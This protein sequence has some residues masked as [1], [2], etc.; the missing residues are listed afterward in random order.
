MDFIRKEISP[1][2]SILIWSRL[3]SE[4][5]RD[6]LIAQAPTLKK[7]W[8]HFQKRL[9]NTKKSGDQEEYTKLVFSSEWLFSAIM[10]FLGMLYDVDDSLISSQLSVSFELQY[11]TRFLELLISL[12]SQLPT[13]R[14]TND[15]LLDTHLIPVIKQS[16]LFKSFLSND[17]VF[18][19]L[20]DLLDYYL[21]L[22]I[23]V[24]TGAQLSEEEVQEKITQNFRKLRQTAFDKFPE[25]AKFL[26]QSNLGSLGT[27]E[28]L[29]DHISTLSDDQLKEFCTYLNFRTSYPIASI[30]ITS[31]REFL[32]EC[33]LYRYETRPSIQEISMSLETMPTEQSLFSSILRLTED[34]NS[35]FP[36]PLPKMALQYLSTLD[37][38]MRSFQLERYESFYDI[39]SDIESALSRLKPQIVAG[40]SKDGEYNLKD[41]QLKLNGSSKMAARI[42]TPIS[43]FEVAPPKVGS[44]NVVTNGLSNLSSSKP[45]FRGISQINSD[46]TVSTSPGSVKAEVV[47][48]LEGYNATPNVVN[49][50]DSL[51]PGEVVF[52]AELLTPNPKSEHACEQAGIRYLR[53]AEI[54]QVLD[55]K[56][57]PIH[58]L[59]RN[60]E[61]SELEFE[62]D[63]DQ[64]VKENDDGRNGDRRKKQQRRI[65]RR[66]LH[67]YLDELQYSKDPEGFYSGLNVV[68]RRRSR[69]N[70]FYP[71]L[72]N[73]KALT[74]EKNVTPDWLTD[75]FL[76]FGDPSSASY[77]S[78]HELAVSESDT[79]I[80]FPN[81][82]DYRDTFLDS[83]HLIE[84]F[85]DR[86]VNVISIR[87]I[88]EDGTVATPPS[89]SSKKRKA[90]DSHQEKVVAPPYVLPGYIPHVS[91][92]A[93][94]QPD[95][96]VL[97]AVS[98]HTPKFGDVKTNQI[99]YTPRQVQALVTSTGPG[100]TVIVGPPGT[101]KTD[102]AVQVVSNLYHN[103]PDQRTL[104]I[105]HSNQALN[106]IFEK[107]VELDVDDKHLLR[108]GGGEEQIDDRVRKS[109]GESFSKYGRVERLLQEKVPL[110]YQVDRLAGSMGVYGAY[111]DSCDTGLAFYR[112][113]VK[114]KWTTYRKKIAELRNKVN[115]SK[116]NKLTDA[117]TS[118]VVDEFPF[119]EYFSATGNDTR[120]GQQ[121]VFFDKNSNAWKNAKCGEHHA[122]LPSATL[123]Q[124][125]YDITALSFDEAVEKAE[126]AYRYIESHFSSLS[127]IRPF[128][129]IRSN[130]AKA[131][132]MLVKQARVIV[133]TAT[134]A[135]M[136]RQEIV[137]MGFHYDNVVVEEAAQLTEIET[138]MLLTLQ[139]DIPSSIRGGFSEVYGEK[140]EEMAE[141]SENENNQEQEQDVNEEED[142][143]VGGFSGVAGI[144]RNG[145]KSG[146]IKQFFGTA[147]ESNAHGDT[148][149]VS[150][151]KS[152]IISVNNRITRVV[153]IGDDRQNAPIIKNSTLRSYSKLDQSL[154]GRLV[155]LNTPL[156]VLDTQGRARPE[157]VTLYDWQYNGD[158]S[159]PTTPFLKHLPKIL[160][161]PLL[162]PQTP[163]A[164]FLDVCQFINVGPYQNQ[165][166]TEP[167]RHFIQ[168]LGEAEYAVAIYQYM[169]LLGYP[170]EKI[171]I[172][173][174]YYGQKKLIEEIATKRCGKP[175]SVFAKSNK[176]ADPASISEIFG[177]PG[178]GIKTVDEYQGEQN[179]Y[180]ILSMVRTKRVGYLRDRRRL[181]VALSRARR[182][183]YVLGYEPLMETFAREEPMMAKLLAFNSTSGSDGQDNKHKLKIVT[184]E[185]Y[186]A[187][188]N[189]ALARHE[190][191]QDKQPEEPAKKK[192]SKS[193]GAKKEEAEQVRNPNAER[194]VFA[195]ENVEHIGQYVHQM[196][197]T[198]RNFLKDQKNMN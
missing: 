156:V 142:E 78:L 135:S 164:G 67:V 195:I 89:S 48:D 3:S 114:P 108:L 25:D 102:V 119:S 72:K 99:R 44:Y 117:I 38:L 140:E 191:E 65:R 123:S 143:E 137:D 160:Q 61:Y 124:Q 163:N 157:I 51:R 173:C 182:G 1:L 196:A 19:Q 16:P 139:K 13:R 198:R 120:N 32:T 127:E 168:N 194:N 54:I 159:D 118:E 100:L 77:D 23:N 42:S 76:G 81:T 107:I 92:T 84:S 82:V 151:N 80:R 147:G 110:L 70:N 79:S 133:M 149:V 144:D 20:V 39:K 193:K 169:R 74:F 10:G 101:G 131:N 125:A 87:D 174:A 7:L 50:W 68:I 98:Y 189:A 161:D 154:F 14:F 141:K 167:S 55:E 47:F 11:I 17:H 148:N 106:H 64:E 35:A 128:E 8:K 162:S 95:K 178:G 21:N 153:L 62:D 53:S 75:V 121:A 166:E 122:A 186:A 52:L 59:K 26:A 69:E 96:Q 33:F 188:D 192:K 71:I 93:A 158:G 176:S 18:P 145:P 105:A 83:E 111:G 36:L 86:S 6:G 12:V 2:V 132:Y 171:T 91:Q 187:V 5:L 56:D 134:Y 27:R 126:D 41:R 103:F 40:V 185:M 190:K 112:M 88:Q 180:I 34:H 97:R 46:A 152:N 155:R 45:D 94:N 146:K 31:S 136:N 175:V 43:I 172:L 73:I 130:K 63:Y 184:G 116:T 29:R 9:I 181:T 58:L 60:D 113:Y 183:L 37:F 15:L 115:K 4:S 165:G 57:R 22:P 49:E 24:F 138:L 170:Q 109:E 197:T 104:V 90:S 150:E 85:P 66:K 30:P 177:Y 179:D 129:L 28:T